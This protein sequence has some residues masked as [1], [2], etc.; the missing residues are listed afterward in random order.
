MSISMYSASIPSFKRLLKNLD[1]ILVKAESYAEEKK[2]GPTVLTSFRL[3][4]DM[5]PLTSQI[6]I[7]TDICKGA[8]ARLTGQEAPVFADTETTFPEL[9]AR[10]AKT[11]EYLEGFKPEQFE[12]AETRHIVLKF[13]PNSFEFT[14]HDYLVNFVLPNIYFHATTCYA[15][16]RHNGVVLG[17]ADFLGR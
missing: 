14:G 8:A 3:F 9:R 12:G 7:A 4:P 2:L 1:A 17:K 11:L 10:I 13:G 16:L 15:M 6:F 5:L